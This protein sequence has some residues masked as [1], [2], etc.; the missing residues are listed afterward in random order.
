MV[1]EDLNKEV[2]IE[3]INYRNSSTKLIKNPDDKLL[4]D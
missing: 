3:N 4:F 2:N 1:N